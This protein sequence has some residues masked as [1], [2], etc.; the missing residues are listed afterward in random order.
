MRCIPWLASLFM[1][2]ACATGSTSGLVAV[3]AWE[4]GPDLARAEMQRLERIQVPRNAELS[5]RALELKGG[6]GVA[7]QQGE[8]LDVICRVHSVDG[9]MVTWQLSL[10]EAATRPIRA[11]WLKRLDILVGS[12]E[13][14]ELVGVARLAE[15]PEVGSLASGEWQRAEE[16]VRT[17]TR[18]RLMLAAQLPVHPELRGEPGQTQRALVFEGVGVAEGGAEESTLAIVIEMTVDIIDR[19]HRPKQKDFKA[20]ERHDPVRE[21]PPRQL[22]HQ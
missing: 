2:S 16:S 5:F 12:T 3:Y 13:T 15:V 1:F 6:A 8:E 21:P 9:G 4:R 20:P 14:P 10:D 22:A 11:T 17:G 7:L 19:D 18:A